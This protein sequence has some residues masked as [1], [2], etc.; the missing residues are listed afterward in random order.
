MS[1]PTHHRSEAHHPVES[2]ESP[3]RTRIVVPVVHGIGTASRSRWAKKSVEPLAKAFIK[4]TTREWSRKPCSA[5][6]CH[7]SDDYTN[8]VH[9]T[10]ESD[11]VEAEL[12]A[13]YWSDAIPIPGWLKATKWTAK[14]A[15]VILLTHIVAAFLRVVDSSAKPTKYGESSIHLGFREL[16]FWFFRF[17]ALSLISIPV[18]VLS[19]LVSIGMAFLP[20]KRKK[21]LL[22][23]MAWTADPESRI[24]IREN[25]TQ[26]VF[27][28][29]F[30]HLVL[31]GHSQGGAI[32]SDV[33]NSWKSTPVP[34]LMTLGSGQVILMVAHKVRNRKETVGAFV[35]AGLAI[36]Y[37]ICALLGIFPM[38]SLAINFIGFVLTS[39]MTISYATW[40]TANDLSQ[41]AVMMAQYIEAQAGVAPAYLAS[42]ITFSFTPIV[43]IVVVFG[44]A[45]CVAGLIFRR[46]ISDVI[47]AVND[48]RLN[49][50]GMDIS[51]RQDYVSSPMS[52]MGNPVR[53]LRIPMR[54]LFPFDHTSYFR[55]NQLALRPIVES[56]EDKLSSDNSVTERA[57]LRDGEVSE[58]AARLNGVGWTI[59]LVAAVLAFSI[60]V[61]GFPGGR[62]TIFLVSLSAFAATILLYIF[63][64][65]VLLNRSAQLPLWHLS[66]AWR[67]RLNSRNRLT[68]AV[69][70][71]VGVFTLGIQDPHAPYMAVLAVAFIASA[72]MNFAGRVLAAPIGA[73]TLIAFGAAW[74]STASILGL[75]V[76]VILIVGA[77]FLVVNSIKRELRTV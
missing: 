34:V 8:H 6:D 35:F 72:I 69:M 24:A 44:G 28:R 12:R 49:A 65:W 21:H 20:Q 13:V 54:G 50:A 43:V 31:V 3:T 66:D 10:T 33:V 48:S 70:L 68:G 67:S 29:Q 1:R 73:I 45:F 52:V 32:L 53:F 5:V 18:I 74:F 17:T 40:V 37:G 9:L 61:F 36:S 15:T 16:L 23:A 46:Q 59:A 63:S 55:H 71:M 64:T 42:A 30:E 14:T 39:G 58:Y 11:T 77:V 22:D 62:V 27:E 51:A 56:V 26:Q 76:G 60:A 4:S 41:G 38:L 7:N 19:T 2:I 47:V 75:V 57:E 25:V